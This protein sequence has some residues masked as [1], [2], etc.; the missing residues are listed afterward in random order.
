MDLYKCVTG[1]PAYHGQFL[2][3]KRYTGQHNSP[4]N[5]SEKG[6][7]WPHREYRLVR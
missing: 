7:L 3:H 6:V 5:H 2:R 4:I 1:D